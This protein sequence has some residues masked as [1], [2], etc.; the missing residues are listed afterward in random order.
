MCFFF[1]ALI[2]GS[3]FSSRMQ[4]VPRLARLPRFP[5]TRSATRFNS[6]ICKMF[7][8]KRNVLLE[9]T[10]MHFKDYV[11]I[12]NTNLCIKRTSRNVFIGELN[13]DLIITGLCWGV[14]HRTCSISM[15]VTSQ[16][17]FRRSLNGQ[18]EAS[19][20]STFGLHSEF[21]R[22]GYK[23]LLQARSISFAL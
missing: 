17:S 13:V 1:S 14:L 3:M 21:S 16:F 18:T 10:P 23:G 7:S 20:P 9:I 11:S 8:K 6:N 22:P 5:I 12:S 4:Q 19:C 2:A 15:I